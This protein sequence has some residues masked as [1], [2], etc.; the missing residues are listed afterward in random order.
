[1]KLHFPTLVLVLF[2]I[3]FT[4]P[5]SGGVLKVAD[6]HKFWAD[7]GITREM[8]RAAISNTNCFAN[9]ET[10]EAC[11]E[12]VADAKREIN[13]PEIKFV[14]DDFDSVIDAV[15]TQLEPGKSKEW[16][17]GLM[18][19]AYVRSFDPHSSVAPRASFDVAVGPDADIHYGLGLQIMATDAGVFVRSVT[20]NSPAEA[21]ALKPFD[22]L[23]EVNGSPIRTG[24]QGYRDCDQIKGEKGDILTLKI[25]RK[26]VE[27]TVHVTIGVVADQ[28]VN[29]EVVGFNSRK[30]AV[31]RLAR[32]RENVC[33]DLKAKILNL[34]KSVS[35]VILDLR[36]NPGGLYEE[37]I[38]VA[39]LF[40][41]RKNI[42]GQ[43]QIP[44]TYPLPIRPREESNDI[45]KWYPSYR[46]AAFPQ[47]PLLVLI[48]QNSASAAEIVAGALQDYERAW[49]VGDVSFG[50]GTVQN[51]EPMQG[52]DSFYQGYTTALFYRPNGSTNQRAGVTPDFP[53]SLRRMARPEEKRGPREGDIYPNSFKP[54]DPQSQWT[55]VRPEAEGLK[56]CVNGNAVD[57]SANQMIISK[58]GSEDYQKAYALGV[59]DCSIGTI[60]QHNSSSSLKKIVSRK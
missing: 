5:I 40:L 38:C 50:K 9:S 49:I 26:G 17:F 1:M 14:E 35:G 36:D 21:A 53:A 43:K 11:R 59:F 23:L 25:Q 24:A 33:D 10:T 41:G 27:K 13:N 58:T 60:A 56:N 15:D 6:V 28:N 55:Q 51:L 54:L 48:N 37:G 47:L 20:A 3:L 39:G 42:V 32:F 8:V 12:A 30:Y 31:I 57:L 2:P 44:V 52:S 19:N 45:I 46:A 22:R 7:S 4:A 34:P 16:I 29:P 18:L